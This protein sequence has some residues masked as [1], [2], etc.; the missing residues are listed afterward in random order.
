MDFHRLAEARSIELHRT[1][2]AMLRHEPAMVAKARERVRR[3]RAEGSVPLAYVEAWERHLAA[4][5]DALCA[6]IV[7]ESEGARALRQVTPFAGFV[8]PRTRWRIWRE[9]RARAEQG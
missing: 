5:L 6:A 1:I 3:W 4:P 7:D 9:V 2:A 8:D